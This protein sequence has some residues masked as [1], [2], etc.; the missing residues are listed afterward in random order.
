[1]AHITAECL[2]QFA[3]ERVAHFARNRW[4]VC[5]GIYNRARKAKYDTANDDIHIPEFLRNPPRKVSHRGR[6]ESITLG[7]SRS[8]KP[9]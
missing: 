9:K 5:S 2:D 8:S 3:L 1:V 7:C 4:P 6:T